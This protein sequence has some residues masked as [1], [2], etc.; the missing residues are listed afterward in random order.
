M[1]KAFFRQSFASLTDEEL[2]EIIQDKANRL[3]EAVEVANELLLSRGRQTNIKALDGL[4]NQEVS[5]IK[6]Q[7]ETLKI[8]RG[9]SLFGL[10][11]VFGVV[12]FFY[13]GDPGS[14]NPVDIETFYRRKHIFEIIGIMAIGLVS[15][16]FSYK[17]SKLKKEQQKT[18]K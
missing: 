7:V 2:L 6:K 9:A 12:L 16:P 17:I 18:L 13:G 11:I 1:D 15:S 5:D 4:Y 10:F 8:F 14:K 3:R